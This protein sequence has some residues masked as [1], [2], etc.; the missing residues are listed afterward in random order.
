VRQLAQPPVAIKGTKDGLL[1]LLDEHCEFE[2][3]VAHLECVLDG[4]GSV[5]FSDAEVPVSIEYGSRQL[6]LTEN[7]ALLDVFLKRE[8]FLIRS[9]GSGGRGKSRHSSVPELPKQS[10]IKGTVRNGQRLEFEGDVVLIG[11]VN[12]GGELVATGD[13]YVFGKLRGIAHAGAAGDSRAIIAAAE[14]GPLQLRIADVVSRSPER[15]SGQALYTF[16]EF[17]YVRDGVMA[18]D[19]MVYRTSLLE[20]MPG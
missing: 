13:V 11:D 12:P 1:F 17:A 19:K 7:R 3:L 10:I 18:V 6:T 8:N 2:K 14:F 20:S 16:M 9:F 5:L 4:E 15:E